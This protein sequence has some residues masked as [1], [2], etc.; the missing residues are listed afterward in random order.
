VRTELFGTGDPLG[1]RITAYVQGLLDAVRADGTHTA[2]FQSPWYVLVSEK[3]V[4]I[5]QGRSYFIWDIQPSWWA[6]TLSKFVVRTPYGI[7]LGSP[8]TMQLAIEEAGLGRILAASAAGAAGKV[9]G[10]RG[11]FYNVAGHSVRAIDGP[12]E[13]SAYPSN[14]SAKLAPARPDEVSAELL[15]ALREALTAA[16]H[17][18][19]AAA[20]AGVVVIDANDIGRNV[21]G[22][23]ADRPARFFE[24]LFGDNPLGQGSEQTPI[25]VA[26]RTG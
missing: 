17:G 5:S 12:T 3:I 20:L 4:A 18:E 16:G 10:K 24:D 2:R 9:L 14:V 23:A 15:G 6:R 21:L 11:V 25:A 13:Y 1:E 22:Q 19:A 8:W 26:V 7:G